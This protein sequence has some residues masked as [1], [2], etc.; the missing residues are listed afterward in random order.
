MQVKFSEVGVNEHFT[1]VSQYPSLCIS[2]I[3]ISTRKYAMDNG[4]ICTIGDSKF[5][6]DVDNTCTCD[7]P[8]PLTFNDLSIGAIF[9][10]DCTWN[11]K[12]DH[13]H[14]YHKIDNMHYRKMFSWDKT[15]ISST[16]TV[17]CTPDYVQ[18]AQ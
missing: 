3:K 11:K 4:T 18:S 13:T 1:F 16:D 9:Q 15:P 10:F 2:G 8:R 7:N 17:V 5:P 6:C 14:I 12:V